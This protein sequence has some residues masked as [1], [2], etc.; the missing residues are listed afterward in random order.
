[1]AG[2]TSKTFTIPILDDTATEAS[3]DYFVFEDSTTE[4]N[5]GVGELQECTIS[6]SMDVAQDAATI[7]DLVINAV[8]SGAPV[9]DGGRDLLIGGT[10]PDTE[11]ST[12]KV[13]TV[14]ITNDT[15]VADETF[16]FK[17]ME[18]ADT[19]GDGGRVIG[20][21]QVKNAPMSLPGVP[22][23]DLQLDSEP[24]ALA[25]VDFYLKLQGVDGDIDALGEVYDVDLSLTDMDKG[26]LPVSMAEY[27]L[28]L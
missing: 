2:E 1:M 3:G 27:C 26:P 10:G 8:I 24:E 4:I 20:W 21:N 22:V 7:D 14:A 25:G 15:V 11:P 12:A 17:A 13:F 16:D 9:G 18:T 19:S 23:V 28:L 6:K 5:I